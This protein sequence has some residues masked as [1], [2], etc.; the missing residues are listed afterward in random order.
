VCMINFIMCGMCVNAWD[1][2]DNPSSLSK[3]I[4]HGWSSLLSFSGDSLPRSPH[5]R[6]RS[7]DN[8]HLAGRSNDD[9]HE[10]APVAG[11]E[12]TLRHA[13]CESDHPLA[14]DCDEGSFPRI[15]TPVY[16]QIPSGCIMTWRPYAWGREEPSTHARPLL[17]ANVNPMV[18]IPYLPSS[19]PSSDLTAT[20]LL[21]QHAH[22]I[23]SEWLSSIHLSQSPVRV[24]GSQTGVSGDRRLP[25]S[26]VPSVAPP[27]HSPL[28]AFAQ[29]LPNLRVEEPVPSPSRLDSASRPPSERSRQ[30]V[31]LQ[32][33][34]DTPTSIFH[35]L[36]DEETIC[37]EVFDEKSGMFRRKAAYRCRKC[38]E[39]KKHHKCNDNRQPAGPPRSKGS[40]ERVEHD[41]SLGVVE[42]DDFDRD[43]EGDEVLTQPG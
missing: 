18:P 7:S 4:G 32:A 38:G 35:P 30:I 5:K 31:P 14:F 15:S 40:S 11:R 17:P 43:F 1:S 36:L 19:A 8:L 6:R 37:L 34:L 9:F 39:I 13:T 24:N 27:I 2:Q 28:A 42:T 29:T 16:L 22:T 21:P 33:V 10:G 3:S 41:A 26:P 20:P 25:A 12:S 23:H